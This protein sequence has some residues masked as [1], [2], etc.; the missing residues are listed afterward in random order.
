M[1]MTFEEMQAIISNMLAV[2]R[3]LQE[4]QLR[5]QESQLRDREDILLLI[6]ET[7]QLSAVQRNIQEDQIRDRQDI[8]L[9]LERSRQ[10]ERMIDRLI[11]YSLSYEA[12][13][14]DLEQRMT[15]LERRRAE[16]GQ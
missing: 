12:D 15:E 3:E 14:L 8:E 10:Q 16:R 6:E 4:S 9:M 5:F 13:K 11:G 7:K 2:Q 1:T